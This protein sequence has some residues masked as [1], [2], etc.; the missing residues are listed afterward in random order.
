MIAWLPVSATCDRP[1]IEHVAAT[2]RERG[3]GEGG[4]AKAV[5]QRSR[6][7]RTRAKSPNDD[8]AIPLGDENLAAVPTPGALPVPNPASVVTDTFDGTG[9]GGEGGGD[10]G[11]DDGGLRGGADGS[12][13]VEGG[14]GYSAVG[15]N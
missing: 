14:N 6:K 5:V 9:G 7:R 10:N 2:G 11:G 8:I 4:H 15:R 1:A 3:R 12:G 13:G